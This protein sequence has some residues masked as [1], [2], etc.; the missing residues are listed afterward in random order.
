MFEIHFVI[1]EGIA[2]EGGAART[3]PLGAAQHPFHAQQKFLQAER[4]CQVVVGPLGQPPDPVILPGT[5]GQ[6]Q[7]RQPRVPPA[8]D[9]A[10]LQAVDAGE[11]QVENDHGD[12]LGR[13]HLEGGFAAGRMLHRIALLLQVV[14]Q[15]AR[16]MR[17]IL[18]QENRR[19]AHTSSWAGS[20]AASGSRMTAVVPRPAPSLSSQARPPC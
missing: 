6:H 11:G 10:D 19:P 2:G 15:A 14:D 9:A 13:G 5:G 7:N 8:Q 17:L 4:L 12:G 3:V 16:D 1:A 20:P 18:H